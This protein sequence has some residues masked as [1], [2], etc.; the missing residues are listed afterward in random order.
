MSEPR[1]ATEEEKTR[2]YGEGFNDRAL[3]RK[4]G[5]GFTG[6]AFAETAQ[7]YRKGWHD[8][9]PRGAQEPSETPRAALRLVGR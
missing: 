5:A 9:A 6:H 4:Y 3:R 1:H 7:A 8:N 2:A